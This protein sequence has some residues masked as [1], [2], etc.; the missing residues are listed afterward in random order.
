MFEPEEEFLFGRLSTPAG[1]VDEAREEAQGLY[2]LASFEP[3]D[4]KP[5][6]MIRLRFRCGADVG[7]KHLW[8]FWTVDGSVPGWTDADEPTGATLRAEARVAETAW[9]T[10]VWGHVE[11]W[12]AELPPQTD[13]ALLQYAALG[14]D[15]AGRRLP[16]PLAPVQGAAP[17]RMRHGSPQVTAVG[18]DRLHS[19]DWFRESVIYSVFVDRFAADPGNTFAPADD[20][21]VVWAERCAGWSRI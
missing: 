15:T 20:L 3:L 17:L 7:L 5:G 19:P 13:G 9:D 18:V 6:E 2:D 21:G 1:R 11:T 14:R 16:C 8:V 12:E 10:L 4:P